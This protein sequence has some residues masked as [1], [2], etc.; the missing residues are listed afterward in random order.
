MVTGEWSRN[1][2]LRT[3]ILLYSIYV[4]GLWL[5]NALFYFHKMSLRPSSV[6]D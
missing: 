6:V 4:S 3:I 1:R 2:F 5:T